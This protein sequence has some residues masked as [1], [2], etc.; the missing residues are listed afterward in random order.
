MIEYR[1][2]KEA[3]TMDLSISNMMQMQKA[4]HALHEQEWYPL[5][6]EYGKDT[7]LFMVEEIGE[8]IAI[9]K[10]KGSNAV[11]EDPKVRQAFLEEMADVLMYYQDTLLRYHITADEISD[12]FARKHARNMGRNYTAEYMEKN[13]G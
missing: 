6:P 8:V 12:A 7:V 11:M 13:Y 5:E 1:K 9:L 3:E 10:K 4:L 2:K